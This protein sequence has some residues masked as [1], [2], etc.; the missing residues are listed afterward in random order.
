MQ[1]SEIR[2]GETVTLSLVGKMDTFGAPMV[3]TKATSLCQPGVRTVLIDMGSVDY[4]TSAGFRA[5]IAIRRKAEHSAIGIALCGLN[6]LIDELFK[7]SGLR[8]NFHIYPDR[9]SALEAIG[10]QAQPNHS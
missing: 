8:S 1:I 2:D 4:M 5:L 7:V 6:E 9:A 3:E 10:K